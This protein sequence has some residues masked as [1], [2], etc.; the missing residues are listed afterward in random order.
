M[1]FN[2][3]EFKST[4]WGTLR[5]GVVGFAV[6]VLAG[7]D[8]AIGDRL[9]FDEP[10]NFSKFFRRVEECTPAEFRRRQRAR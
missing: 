2:W 8:A 10:T 5:F 4:W 9:G 6:G 1:L 7:A 3:L